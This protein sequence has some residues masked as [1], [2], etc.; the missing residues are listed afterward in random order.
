M[1]VY[2]MEMEF[3]VTVGLKEINDFM[4]L[5]GFE[6]KATLTGQIMTLKQTIPFIPDEV[7]LRKV[8][9]IIHEHYET[10]KFDIIDCK[11]KGCE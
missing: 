6:E 3:E 5:M 7:Y 10:E 8:E 2:E 9:G 11:F 4:N 1:K